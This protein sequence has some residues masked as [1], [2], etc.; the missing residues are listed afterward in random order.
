MRVGNIHEGHVIH[1]L[2]E[3]DVWQVGDAACEV[4]ACLHVL[5]DAGDDAPS[6]KETWHVLVRL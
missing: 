4:R 5:K 3:H 2:V 6:R 1:Q